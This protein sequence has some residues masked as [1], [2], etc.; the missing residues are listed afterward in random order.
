MPG[1]IKGEEG[2][3]EDGGQIEF[4]KGIK[5]DLGGSSLFVEQ[6]EEQRREKED[7]G[8]KKRGREAI[9]LESLCG[10][11]LPTLKRRTARGMRG[12]K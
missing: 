8:S 2:N 5:K 1:S 4:E 11:Q 12:Y 6:E 7:F 3:I 9:V 10:A